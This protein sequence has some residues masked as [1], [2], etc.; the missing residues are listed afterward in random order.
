MVYTNVKTENHCLSFGPEMVSMKLPE[1]P[2]TK[3]QLLQTTA[4]FYDPLELFSPVSVVGKMLFQ[5]MM[6]GN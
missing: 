6:Q 4:R 3:R 2:T 5:D 1:G